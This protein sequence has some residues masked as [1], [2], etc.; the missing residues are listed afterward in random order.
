MSGSAW[1]WWQPAPQAMADASAAPQTF[2]PPQYLQLGEVPQPQPAAPAAGSGDAFVQKR[3]RAAFEGAE[4]TG[5]SLATRP[6]LRPEFANAAP[7]VGGRPVPFHSH[8]Q[9]ASSAPIL[10]QQPTASRPVPF[11]NAPAPS[12]QPKPTG[13]VPFQPPAGAM[14]PSPRTELAPAASA[15]AQH[16]V[17]RSNVPVPFKNPAQLASN[18][19]VPF[20]SVMSERSVQAKPNAPLPFKPPGHAPQ[21]SNAP[22]PRQPRPNSS[23]PVPFK[24]SGQAP[25][26]DP[27]PPLGL[28]GVGTS[29]AQLGWRRPALF[30]SAP[31]Q[32]K[33]TGP[34]PLPFQRPASAPAPSQALRSQNPPNERPS[35]PVF[36]LE[37]PA[38]C[39]REPGGMTPA[40]AHPAP[41]DE[42]SVRLAQGGGGGDPAARA[43]QPFQSGE[44]PPPP[45]AQPLQPARPMPFQ[46]PSSELQ[47]LSEQSAATAAEMAAKD[48][49]IAALQAE[50][51]RLQAA[52]DAAQARGQ[53]ED[54]SGRVASAGQALRTEAQRPSTAPLPCQQPESIPHG[55]ALVARPS[56]APIAVPVPRPDQPIPVRPGPAAA[57]AVRSPNRPVPF[58]N[59]AREASASVPAPAP[60]GDGGDAAAVMPLTQPS[61]SSQGAAS[62][63]SEELN[64]DQLAAV[65]AV[66]RGENVFITGPAGTGKSRVLKAIIAHLRAAHKREEWIVT[67]PTGTAAVALEGQTL[68]SFAGVGV[69]KHRK[70][71]GRAWHAESEKTKAGRPAWRALKAL[72]VDEVSML[73]AEFFDLLSDAVIGVRN[74]YRGIEDARPFGG[75]QLILC[76]DFLQLPPIPEKADAVAEAVA[77]LQRQAARRRNGSTFNPEDVFQNRGFTFQAAAWRDARLTVVVLKEVFRQREGDFISALH[78]IRDGRGGTAAVKALVHQCRRPLPPRSDGTRPTMLYST[79]KDADAENELALRALPAD[80]EAAV[81]VAVDEVQ[82]IERDEGGEEPID[83]EEYDEEAMREQLWNNSFWKDCRARKELALK[84]GAQVMLAKNEPREGQ[85]HPLVN[86]SRGVVIG[87]EPEPVPEDAEETPAAV[88]SCDATTSHST[89]EHTVPAET[90]RPKF[91]VVKFGQRT[92]LVTPEEFSCEVLGLGKCVREAV[93]LRLAWAITT[94]KSQGMSLDYVVADLQGAFAEAQVYVALS[95][96]TDAGGLEVRNFRETK[97]MANALARRFY[98]DPHAAQPHWRDDVK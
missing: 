76:G 51:A 37:G 20:Q 94:H 74:R 4:D 16:S 78:Q 79:N 10:P 96:A 40:P 81:Y 56:T 87:F 82:L 84:V 1:C 80:A 2:V 3:S 52:L 85:S 34:V 9:P 30:Q 53:G 31:V 50:V 43:P 92:K 77:R 35:G 7:C 65:A 45:S 90:P 64:A 33:A 12:A 69:P 66:R 29:F 41:F 38:P 71:F 36:C 97:V 72:V 32:P 68:H 44:S 98:A 25:A 60:E 11:Q 46:P 42:R 21:A 95:R 70:D 19:P 48:A 15:P 86:G 62:L 47:A 67:A 27:I 24:P 91:P 83:R 28:T 54:G 13:P 73:S 22:E 8:A 14:A 88:T 18:R 93:P 5:L 55:P 61:T 23:G 39:V 49:T 17:P 57:A 59:P 26:P 63:P 6:C 58:V 75:V 89:G